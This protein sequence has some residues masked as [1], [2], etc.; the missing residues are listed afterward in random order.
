[1]TGRNSVFL[2]NFK[3]RYNIKYASVTAKSIFWGTSRI[4]VSDSLTIFCPQT[5]LIAEI[6]LDVNKK[7]K[8]K[9]ENVSGTISYK[10]GKKIYAVSGKLSG[11]IIKDLAKNKMLKVYEKDT[12]KVPPIKVTPVNKQ[13]DNE[14]RKYKKYLNKGFGIK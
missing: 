8:K 13:S 10:D 12:L 9:A 3:E 6:S 2:E 5:K 14:S 1:V 11:V 7:I 4:E